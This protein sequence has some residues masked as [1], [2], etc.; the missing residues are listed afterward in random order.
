MLPMTVYQTHSPNAPIVALELAQTQGRHLALFTLAPGQDAQSAGLR[1]PALGL[2]ILNETAVGDHKLVVA[3]GAA[4][5]EALLQTLA[6][7][8]T[9]LSPQPA[10]AP[11]FNAWLWRGLSSLAGQ[12]LNLWA[13]LTNKT[14]PAGE[15]AGIIGFAVPNLIANAINATF[16]GQKKDD[17]YQL[18][19]LKSAINEALAPYAATALPAV[20][21]DL[22]QGRSQES[23]SAQSGGIG[24]FIARHSVSAGEVGLRILGTV[25]L[26]LPFTRWAQG[27]RTLRQGGT[28]ARAF[29]ATRNPNPV[30]FWAG[31]TTMVGKITAL[32]A[33]EPDPYNPAPPDTLRSLRENVAFKASSVI[34][35]IGATTMSIDDYRHKNIQGAIGNGIFVGGYYIRYFAPFGT[36][37]V[38]RDELFAHAAAA[39]AAAQPAHRACALTRASA[40]LAQHFQGAKGLSLADCYQQIAQGLAKDHGI[41]IAPPQDRET[42]AV[43][44]DEPQATQAATP[45]T[46]VSHSQAQPRLLPDAPAL[47]PASA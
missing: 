47:S 20:E 22:Y 15:K 42:S 7:G 31:V 8:G 27:V 36:R 12:S 41:T 13:G 14:K 29:E 26:M 25:S 44:V 32:T 45:S 30:T 3:D 23:K 9:V 4:K 34:E 18:R 16:G 11:K 37:E 6:A 39:V 17:P 28:L 40:L 46:Q 35:G 38:D 43:S 10:A 21:A 2:H 19:Y 5:P 1:N 33:R 24:G